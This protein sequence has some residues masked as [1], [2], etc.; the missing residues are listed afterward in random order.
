M[1]TS[2]R[3]HIRRRISSAQTSH[4]S[5]PLPKPESETSPTS[6]SSLNGSGKTASEA[7]CPVSS[8]TVSI[9]W[10]ENDDTLPRHT[11]RLQIELAECVETKTVT[12]T[13]TTKRSYP[14]LLVRQPL[15]LDKLDS[16][17]YPLA[18]KPIPQELCN[19]SYEIEGQLIDFRDGQSQVSNVRHHKSFLDQIAI[20]ITSDIEYAY[21]P[22]TKVIPAP[23]QPSGRVEAQA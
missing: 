3:S 8:H 6:F 1:D 9:N 17:E 16:K 22:C 10:D 13:T 20:L 7:R 11:S 21:A 5:S 14:P 19:F 12:T 15:S 4:I 18:L 2:S 23:K